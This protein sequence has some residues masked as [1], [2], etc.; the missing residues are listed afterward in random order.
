MNR[1]KLQWFAALLVACAGLLAMGQ[2]V[3]AGHDAWMTH[4][5]QAGVR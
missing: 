2:P 5:P 1:D 3:R 4:G